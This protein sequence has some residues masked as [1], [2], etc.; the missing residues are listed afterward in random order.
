MRKFNGELKADSLIKGLEMNDYD[1][2]SLHIPYRPGW[3]TRQIEKLVYQT[4]CNGCYFTQLTLTDG[5]LLTS[6]RVS[7]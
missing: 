7:E 2:Q 6:H 4:V 1:V 3:N 5:F